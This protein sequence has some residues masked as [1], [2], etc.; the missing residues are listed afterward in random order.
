[1]SSR[2][3]KLL[4]GAAVIGVATL[5][6]PDIAHAATAGGS[7]P[8]DNPLTTLKNDLTGPVA[9]SISLI[10]FFVMGA[11]LVWGGEIPEF[12]RRVVFG[13]LV[14]CLLVLGNNVAAA[15]GITGAIV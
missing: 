5:F 15:L 2:K 8:W 1:M 3:G 10:G 7:M 12:A 6:A 13:V 4:A 11:T 9:F 14:M